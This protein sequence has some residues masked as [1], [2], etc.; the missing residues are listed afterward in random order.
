MGALIVMPTKKKPKSKPHAHTTGR[1][2][3]D[4]RADQLAVAPEA[5]GNDDDLLTTW[6]V[7]GWLR[8]STQWLDIGR[9]K[10]YGPPYQRLSPSLIRYRRGGVRGW[11]AEREH[12]HTSRFENKIRGSA[13]V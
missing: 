3:L 6:E 13:A 9:I 11:L 8:V 5:T 7:A 10:G 12:A 4:K 2:Q 1:F